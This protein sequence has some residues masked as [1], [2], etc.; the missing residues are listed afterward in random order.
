[1]TKKDFLK[2]KLL[3]LILLLF[4]VIT[5]EIFLIIYPVGF[6]LKIYIPIVV[7]GS[8]L[9]GIL[10][11]YYNKKRFYE[12]ALFLL[13]ELEEKFKLNTIFVPPYKK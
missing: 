10:I 9:L 5:I 1:M 8:Y 2:D 4:A 7:L 3:N 11:E 12:K 13:N 6:L